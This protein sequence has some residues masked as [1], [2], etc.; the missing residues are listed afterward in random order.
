MKDQKSSI[1]KC[2]PIGAR[3]DIVD[4][5]GARIAQIITVVGFKSRT[6]R[7]M[8]AGIGDL[9]KVAVKE[10]KPDMRHKMADVVII[11]QKKEFMR[12]D[13]TKV[14]FEDNAGIVLKDVRLGIPKGTMLKGPIAKE[15]AIRWPA[16]AKIATMIL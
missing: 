4:N 14:Q 8:T 13:G 12:P 16:V 6:K 11:R 1:C 7:L 10:G 3:L 2:L 15:V 5:S 9:V